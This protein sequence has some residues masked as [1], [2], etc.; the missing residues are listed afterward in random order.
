VQAP[1]II[2]NTLSLG[3]SYEL[4]EDVTFSFA[5]MHGFRNAIEGPILQVP[6]SSVRLDAQ[7]DTLWAGVNIKFGGSKRKGPDAVSSDSLDS[8]PSAT[9]SGPYVPTPPD[10]STDPSPTS[11]SKGS[12]SMPAPDVADASE[13][14]APP[15]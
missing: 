6:G 9:W 3:A 14:T 12:S 7:L 8:A 15:P 13:A 5:W 10:T 2:Q 11:S 1:G 4:T